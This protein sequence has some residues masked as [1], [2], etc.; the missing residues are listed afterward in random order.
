MPMT[1]PASI[2]A[3]R[4]TARV[5]RVR[6]G[7]RWGTVETVA[8]AGHPRLNVAEDTEVEGGQA[9]GSFEGAEDWA[10]ALSEE[11]GRVIESY[12]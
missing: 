7:G 5:G 10:V 11:R 4:D 8:A 12:A 2:R 6:A 1:F 9:G 3:W